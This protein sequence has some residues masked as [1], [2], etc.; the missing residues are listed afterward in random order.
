MKRLFLYD[1]D[2][3]ITTKDS[4]FDFLKFSTNSFKYYLVFCAFI[5]FFLGAKLNL[6][7][8]GD[9]KRRFISFFLK[10]KSKHE[11]TK[12]SQA[13]LQHIIKR[14]M[15]RE[16][17]L[18]SI[19]K[20]KDEGDVYLVS[21]SLDIWLTPIA[22]WLDIGLIC[23]K[24]S[25]SKDIYNGQF[26]TPNCN[27]DEKVIRV[28]DEIDMDEYQWKVYHGDSSGDLAMKDLVDEYHHQLF[29]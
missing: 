28:N 26:D 14:P 9:V 7:Q 19:R 24:A 29:H 13:Y 15:F 23:T 25:Y 10:G 12:I 27:Y 3:T 1:F 21:A 6:F 4:L 17:A 20:H 16:A 18:N 8:K 5:P 22:K 2:G 11:L